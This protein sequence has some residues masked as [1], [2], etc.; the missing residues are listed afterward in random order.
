MDEESKMNCESCH[1]KCKAIC[2]SFATPLPRELFLKNID[3]RQ[4]KIININSISGLH[5]VVE[6]DTDNCVFLSADFK[7]VIYDERPEICQKFGDESDILM[8]CSY[9]TKDG[10]IRSRQQ[11][12]A[13][14]AKKMKVIETRVNRI[15]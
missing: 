6:T 10:E 8:T 2:C 7:C 9:Q 15:N 11:V 3:K 12:R 13:I 4:A 5:V 1:S 14:D